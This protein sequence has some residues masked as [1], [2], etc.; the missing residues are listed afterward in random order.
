MVTATE[1]T[2]IATHNTATCVQMFQEDLW[3]RFIQIELII[4]LKKAMR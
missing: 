3:D 1:N 2:N 4:K